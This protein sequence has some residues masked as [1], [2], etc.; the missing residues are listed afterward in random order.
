V[1]GLTLISEEWRQY[2][3]E[4][5]PMSVRINANLARKSHQDNPRVHCGRT[6]EKYSEVRTTGLSISLVASSCV[7]FKIKV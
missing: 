4:N 5:H 2:R 7:K 1:D 3:K 6:H